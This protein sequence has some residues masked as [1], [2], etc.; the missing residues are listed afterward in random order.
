MVT[1][2]NQQRVVE[3]LFRV[4]LIE[5][6]LTKKVLIKTIGLE[7]TTHSLIHPDAV[8]NYFG[9]NGRF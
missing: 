1:K 5:K 3:E 6:I 2:E 4:E 7:N 8:Y 9:D